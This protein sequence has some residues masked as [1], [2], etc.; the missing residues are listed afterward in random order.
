MVLY[1]YLVNV[2]VLRPIVPTHPTNALDKGGLKDLD[3]RVLAHL[4]FR[5]PMVLR[6]CLVRLSIISY[7]LIKPVFGLI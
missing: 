4:S 1:H 2:A 5:R 7:L 6:T 3:R